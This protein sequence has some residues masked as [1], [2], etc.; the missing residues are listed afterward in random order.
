[1]HLPSTGAVKCKVIVPVP[2]DAACLSL[3]ALGSNTQPSNNGRH[4][5]AT[6][7]S[8]GSREKRGKKLERGSESGRRKVAGVECTG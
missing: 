8:L 7:F 1:M 6:L 2:A 4:S 3:S 5:A